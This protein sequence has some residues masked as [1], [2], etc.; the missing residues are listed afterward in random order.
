MLLLCFT[1]SCE[2]NNAT[3][4]RWPIAKQL[5]SGEVNLIGMAM[6]DA[7]KLLPPEQ[8]NDIRPKVYNY[9]LG[10]ERLFV[11]ELPMLLRGDSVE[12]T[13]RI[14]TDWYLF[15]EEGSLLAYEGVPPIDFRIAAF[16]H[17]RPITDD[18]FE[19]LYGDLRIN[20]VACTPMVTSDMRIVRLLLEREDPSFRLRGIN[21]YN[22]LT[23]ENESVYRR[24]LWQPYMIGIYRDDF[25]WRI[26]T[27]AEDEEI[28]VAHFDESGNVLSCNGVPLIDRK[29][30]WMDTFSDF[31]MLQANY[32]SPALV[33]DG[34]TQYSHYPFSY[35]YF[36]R[37]GY[38]ICIGVDSDGMTILGCEE[39]FLG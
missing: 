31:N 32:G 38:L 7:E 34:L 12:Q 37:D 17:T 26:Y 10:S 15:S 21:V 25:T 28:A 22:P 30:P 6:S 3:T 27:Y 13:V 1:L 20:D 11:I 16:D 35:A 4:D 5:I 8:S 36:T 18:D 19:A 39:V 33:L 29:T 14:V 9:I 23:D 2:R 24:V